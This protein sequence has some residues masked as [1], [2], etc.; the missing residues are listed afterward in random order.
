MD[1]STSINWK[2]YD[3][4]VT[5]VDSKKLQQFDIKAMVERY[6]YDF[7]TETNLVLDELGPFAIDFNNIFPYSKTVAD[8][9]KTSTRLFTVW[10]EDSISKEV[11]GISKGHILLHHFDM[12]AMGDAKGYYHE[13]LGNMENIIPYYPKVLIT[14]CRTILKNDDIIEKYIQELL[15]FIEKIW[16]ALRSN[17]I[18]SSEDLNLKKRY[19]KCFED[20]IY[21]T[22]LIPSQENILMRVLRKKNYQLSGVMHLMSRKEQSYDKAVL[23][24]HIQR[25]QTEL[26]K[27]N[28]IN[29]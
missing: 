24:H 29:T 27:L 9:G 22:F 10:A 4:R 14:S 23:D 28:D 11:I 15:Q 19:I 1:Q 18:N 6:G 13:E 3:G 2:F 26:R 21:V 16:K 12:I 5:P 20:I 8:I 7:L 25:A 17:I